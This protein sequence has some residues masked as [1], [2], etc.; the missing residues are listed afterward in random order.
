VSEEDQAQHRTA[1]AVDP[2]WPPPVGVSRG[3]LVGV[4]PGRRAGI[5]L[6]SRPDRDHWDWRR[7]GG[8]ASAVQPG[9]AESPRAAA[10]PSGLPA[11][12]APSPGGIAAPAP[13][14]PAP[15]PPV[16]AP[17]EAVQLPVN[18]L[19]YAQIG[20][21]SG[22]TRCEVIQSWVA[23]AAAMNWPMINGSPAHGAKVT[24]SGESRWV[25]GNLGRTEYKI[26]LGYQTYR[27]AG[28]TITATAAGTTFTN[29]RTG[30][31]RSVSVETVSP[32]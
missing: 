13:N 15:P 11:P 19:G 30:H 25:A 9:S 29:D 21:Q 5:W 16:A 4:T 18:P 6:A 7:S 23:E 14:Q 17:P 31:G 1:C 20:T 2:T 24:D 12:A 3:P 8:H 22:K 26:A 28:W 27:A 10:A 32:F